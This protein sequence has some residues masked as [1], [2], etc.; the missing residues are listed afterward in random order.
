MTALGFQDNKCIL[1]YLSRKLC[2][3][4]S[5]TRGTS[6]PRE[7]LQNEGYLSKI[8][9]FYILDFI[10]LVSLDYRIKDLKST[11]GGCGPTTATYL[12]IFLVNNHDY[13]G[14]QLLI[15][16]I[17]TFSPEYTALINAFNFFFSL[18]QPFHK[19]G[20]IYCNNSDSNR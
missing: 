10:N 6:W 1:P 2:S 17:H 14:R 20:Y 4:V 19:D 16:V 5:G 11:L 13:S 8:D 9:W 7:W 3:Q 18:P 12:F 15:T